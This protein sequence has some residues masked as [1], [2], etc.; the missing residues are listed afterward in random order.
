M[1]EL[2]QI[3]QAAVLAGCTRQRIYNA[4]R[5]Q[6]LKILPGAPSH[7]PLLRRVDV[8]AWAK[9]PKSKG[10]RPKKTSESPPISI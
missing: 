7:S 5:R 1:N 8:E 10:G 4:I 3:K 6:E 9:Q 2:L